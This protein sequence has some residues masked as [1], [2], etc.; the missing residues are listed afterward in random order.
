MLH[1]SFFVKNKEFPVIIKQHTVKK[2]MNMSRCKCVIMGSK[3]AFFTN[4]K[5]K[6]FKAMMF[7]ENS[8]FMFHF[9]KHALILGYL[10]RFCS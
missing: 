3:K 10:E 9:K 5:M 1:L 2:I 4:F 7:T 8:H 6:F